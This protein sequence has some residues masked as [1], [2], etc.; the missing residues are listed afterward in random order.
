[1]QAIGASRLVRAALA[2]VMLAAGLAVLTGFD[3]MGHRF[4][5]LGAPDWMR[6]LAGAFQIAA[7]V[8]LMVPGR[9][10]YGAALCLIA[11][12]AATLAHLAVLGWDSAP[13]AMALAVLSALI[14][15]HNRADLQR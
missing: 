13:P 3:R 1:M 7:A 5:A 4:H 12:S 15:R 9:A 8:I 2:L 11:A 14:L 6:Y 10:G